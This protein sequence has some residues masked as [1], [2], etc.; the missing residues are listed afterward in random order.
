MGCSKEDLDEGELA[1]SRETIENGAVEN[2]MIHVSS[3][4]DLALI[5]S[6]SSGISKKS[7]A[8]Y[9]K[10][11][12]FVSLLSECNNEMNTKSDNIDESESTQRFYDLNNYSELIPNEDLAEL[13]NFQAEILIGDTIYRI[14]EKGTFFYHKNQ[15]AFILDNF[16][17]LATTEGSEISNGIYEVS[18]GLFLHKT[19]EADENFTEEENY[20]MSTRDIPVSSFPTYY[21]DAKTIVGGWIQ[22]AIGRNIAHTSTFSSTRRIKCKLYYYNYQFYQETGVLGEIQKKNWIGWSGTKG[23][24]IAMGFDAI[25][26]KYGDVAGTETTTPQKVGSYR[27]YSPVVGQSCDVTVIR[28]VK[29]DS[30]LLRA[31]KE[32]QSAVRAFLKD[33]KN[34]SIDKSLLDVI[35]FEQHKEAYVVSFSDNKSKE[36]LEKY[37]EVISSDFRL[38]VNVSSSNSFSSIK[39]YADLVG[40]PSHIPSS[41]TLVYASTYVAGRIGTTWKGVKLIKN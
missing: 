36:N 25:V 29:Y 5:L 40:Q 20:T 9:I 11:V 38:L 22:S 23:D 3:K 15:D 18:D 1:N 26:M 21:T 35:V 31:I 16:E 41:P 10:P 19:F 12:Q 28:G 4:N 6:G 32:G 27:G 13:L 17:E 37:R 39:D 24:E 34:L 2:R 30:E 7:T 14:T 8:S 33:E